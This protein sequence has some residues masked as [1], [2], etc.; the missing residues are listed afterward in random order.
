[1]Y[2]VQRKE[3][4]DVLDQRNLFRE[5]SP[6]QLRSWTRGDYHVDVATPQT[7]RNSDIPAVRASKAH[8]VINVQHLKHYQP[9]D[10]FGRN[11]A[12]SPVWVA[13]DGD[14]YEPD[15]IMKHRMWSGHRDK[16]PRVEY[17]ISWV[18]YGAEENSWLTVDGRQ[19]LLL[20]NAEGILG[21]H[22]QDAAGGHAAL[23]CAL[24]V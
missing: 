15:Q 6:Q 9:S 19:Q 21:W 12:L 3:D 5:L 13:A 20:G 11:D 17:L 4:G 16:A 10:T 2:D 23:S 18:E 1:V 24:V 7:L 22:R 8:D 14:Y